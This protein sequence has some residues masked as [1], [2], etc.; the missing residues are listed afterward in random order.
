MNDNDYLQAQ[1][2]L[3][4]VTAFGAVAARYLVCGVFIAMIALLATSPHGELAS[5]FDAPLPLPAELG[6][7]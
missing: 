7:E 6:L 3:Q 5:A 4:K 2:A 1:I